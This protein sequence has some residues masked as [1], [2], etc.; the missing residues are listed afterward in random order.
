MGDI[1]DLHFRSQCD[2]KH[3]LV[4]DFGVL[5]GSTRFVD[6][7]NRQRKE[8]TE[9]GAIVLS[10]EVVT[11]QSR[12]Q[13]PQHANPDLKQRLDE[14][15]KRKID[16]ADRVLVLNVGGYI[17]E[18]TKAE[19]RYARTIGRP[20]EWLEGPSQHWL[21]PCEE[22]PGDP[23]FGTVCHCDI[24]VDH[25]ADGVLADPDAARLAVSA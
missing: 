2:E 24:G 6:E 13:D 7:F 22:R 19:V 11:T 4:R 21:T 9:A 3:D 14:L 16:L 20:V 1:N 12:E 5:C 18:S 17:G 15:H 23:R 10:I 25:D 8:L